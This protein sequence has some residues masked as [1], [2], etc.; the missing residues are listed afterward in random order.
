MTDPERRLAELWEADE[1][2]AQDPA[3]VIAVMERVERRRMIAAWAW[4]AVMT[5]A[6]A[7]VAWALAPVMQG[8]AQPLV[9]AGPDLGAI[10]AAAVLAAALW[11]WA[12]EHA[13]PAEA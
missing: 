8:L 4:L 9:R 10:T 2:T 7:V 6:S 1:P 5:P 13:R 12:N 3:F 11:S